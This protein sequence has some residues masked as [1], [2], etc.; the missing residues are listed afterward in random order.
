M[1]F[2]RLMPKILGILMEQYDA[3]EPQ[4]VDGVV[5]AP[6]MELIT[7]LQGDIPEQVLEFL[8]GPDPD[9]QGALD[10]LAEQGDIVA[11][12]RDFIDS[13]KNGGQR[14][15]TLIRRIRRL[16]IGD[17]AAPSNRASIWQN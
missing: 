3:D 8:G 16:W 14:R 15:R 10:F 9:V 13:L 11:N 1:S 5:W 17:D 6:Y 2:Q 4:L 12:I 7:K